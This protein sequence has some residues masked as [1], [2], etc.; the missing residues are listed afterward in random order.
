M[1]SVLLAFHMTPTMLPLLHG[2]RLCNCMILLLEYIGTCVYVNVS[3]ARVSWAGL[4]CV[5][6][7]LIEQNCGHDSKVVK[8]WSYEIV[9]NTLAIFGANLEILLS[10]A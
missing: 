8:S 1:L 5:L 6:K 4:W 3:Y 7:G 10:I 9:R 2:I